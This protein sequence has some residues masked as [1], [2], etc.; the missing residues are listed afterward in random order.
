MI[1]IKNLAV[2]LLTCVAVLSTA[3]AAHAF[4]WSCMATDARAREYE[5]KSFGIISPWVRQIATK[6]AMTA[7]E[8]AGGKACK[9]KDCV[10]L[11]VQPRQ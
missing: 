7:C 2:A 8:D 3:P 5:G 6:R 1:R 9:L 11:D 4:Y 10:D